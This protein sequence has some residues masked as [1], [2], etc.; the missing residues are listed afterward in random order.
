VSVGKLA[1]AAGLSV[2]ADLDELDAALGEL[3]GGELARRG[4]PRRKDTEFGD[5]DT[6]AGW[7]SDEVSWLRQCANGVVHLD[8]DSY[9]PAVSL[10]LAADW[11][12]RAVV[13]TDLAQVRAVIDRIAAEVDELARAHR[14]QDLTTTAVLSDPRGGGEDAAGGWSGP[15]T[16][17]RPSETSAARSANGPATPITVPAALTTTPCHSARQSRS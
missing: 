1:A 12:D 11:P 14:V 17:G 13:T 7:L 15:G 8:A 6:I 16:P 2:G 9:P 5:R 4:G 3:P 10:R